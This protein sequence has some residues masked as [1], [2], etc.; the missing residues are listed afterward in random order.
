[1]IVF[2]GAN[3]DVF[4]KAVDELILS[5]SNNSKFKSAIR[6]IEKE[7]QLKG[8]T[9]YQLIFEIIQQDILNQRAQQWIKNK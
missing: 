8:K 3:D 7:S 4:T 6:N 1:M 5:S 9:L 2:S